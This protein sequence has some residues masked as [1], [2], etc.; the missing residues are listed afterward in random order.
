MYGEYIASLSLLIRA[1]SHPAVSPVVVFDELEVCLKVGFA[2]FATE[3]FSRRRT[4]RLVI[5]DAG[6]RF[7]VPLPAA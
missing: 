7:S 6:S 4:I 2:E 1:W 5:H 3:R